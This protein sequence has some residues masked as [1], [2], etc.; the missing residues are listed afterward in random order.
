MNNGGAQNG[1]GAGGGPDD[2]G[3]YRWEGGYEKTWEAIQEDKEGMLDI[4][5]QV[6]WFLKTDILSF[7]IDAHWIKVSV[8]HP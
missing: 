1:G 4:S 2:E 7:R 5:V 6:R 8:V 3:G